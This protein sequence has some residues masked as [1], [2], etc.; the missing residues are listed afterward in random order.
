M[1]IADTSGLIAAFGADASRHR[2]ARAAY[3][4]DPGP[5]ILSPF[6]LAELDYLLLTRAGLKAELQLLREVAAG[7]FELASFGPA[8]VSLAADVVEQYADLRLGLADASLVVLAD[9]YQTTRLLTFDERHFRAVRPLRAD[10]FTL[11]PSDT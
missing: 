2:Q 1:I 9:R 4:N 11:L 5:V 10:A 8:E 3:E 7:V 6:V